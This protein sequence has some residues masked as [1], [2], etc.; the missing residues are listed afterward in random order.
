MR[1]RITVHSSATHPLQ[2]LRSL[3]VAAFVHECL[4]LLDRRVARYFG[5]GNDR[6]CHESGDDSATPNRQEANA[7]AQKHGRYRPHPLGSW[8][9]YPAQAEEPD[10]S[11][12]GRRYVG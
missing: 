7:I 10:E 12:E 1:M 6:F 3:I 4:G 11:D 5:S 2:Q 9:V 8:R